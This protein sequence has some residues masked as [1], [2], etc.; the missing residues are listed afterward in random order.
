MSKI[1]DIFMN[2][3]FRYVCKKNLY[4]Q[5]YIYN[6][7]NLESIQNFDKKS[8]I[9]TSVNYV[10]VSLI[11]F[12]CAKVSKISQNKYVKINFHKLIAIALINIPYVLEQ[13]YI[14]GKK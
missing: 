9:I 7:N 13:K 6:T 11:F 8:K 1:I 2:Y 14:W 4:D 10:P 5:L 12:S 3:I